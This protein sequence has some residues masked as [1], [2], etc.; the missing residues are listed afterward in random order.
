MG[1]GIESFYFLKYIELEH[2]IKLRGKLVD[3]GSQEYDVK[4]KAN[5]FL[6]G[7]HAKK[8]NGIDAGTGAYKGPLRD[9]V[10][11]IGIQNYTS[12]DIDGRFGAIPIDFN[13]PNEEYHTEDADF[14]F[15]LG[16]SEHVFDQSEIFRMMH[17]VLRPGGIF[18]HVLPYSNYIDHG[19]FSYSPCFFYSLAAYNN[20]EIISI[21]INSSLSK[22]KFYAVKDAKKIEGR[23]NIIVL[24][25]KN[26][27]N[28]FV[29]PL[30][31]NNP[32]LILPQFE[33]CEISREQLARNIK[34]AS[35]SF[36]WDPMKNESRPIGRFKPHLV[37][38]SGGLRFNKFFRLMRKAFARAV[39][40]IVKK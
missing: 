11:E 1:F 14:V 19:L 24:M 34:D 8:L 9:Y 29:K 6:L 26:I 32:M 4:S 17:Q 18:Y 35:K 30:Q 2:N 25:R 40:S 31:F 12:F 5:N 15:N 23:S 37:P 3:F 22:E 10:S 21:F 33:R 20:Y 16:T 27:N 38:S 28:L 13:L 39:A 7:C 36:I